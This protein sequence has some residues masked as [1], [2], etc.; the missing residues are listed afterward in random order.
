MSEKIRYLDV[1]KEKNFILIWLAQ[2]AGLVGFYVTYSILILVVFT[3]SKSNFSVALMNATLLFPAIFLATYGGTFSDQNNKRKILFVTTLARAVL[4]LTLLFL[5]NDSAALVALFFV[6]F[7]FAVLSQFFVPAEAAA[8][9]VLIPSSKL[10][11]ANT[12]F[13]LTLFA[14]ILIGYS[15]GSLLFDVTGSK[16]PLILS[17]GLFFLATFLTYLLPDMP[18]QEVNKIKRTNVFKGVLVEFLG[19]ISFMW[20]RPL[21][22]R[23][24]IQLMTSQIVLGVMLALAPA[25]ILEVVGLE[26]KKAWLLIL[27]AGVGML[28]G[29]V[30]VGWFAQAR[31]KHRISKSALLMVGILLAALSAVREISSL[32]TI[33]YPGSEAHGTFIFFVILILFFIGFAVSG[34]F[35][36]AQTSLQLDAQQNERGKV[37][38]I[39][40]MTINIMTVFPLLI[41]GKFADVFDVSLVIMATAVLVSIIALVQFLSSGENKLN[42]PVVQ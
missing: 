9:P 35:V 15:S 2:I 31:D 25:F 37:F 23:S 22:R 24:I 12:L 4:V 33:R 39:L 17:A 19:S 18:P 7:L 21:I 36:P 1:L 8:I 40:N 41:A 30:L 20:R 27:P 16:G 10:L 42:K 26:I 34:V 28:L 13:S 11:K 14:S 38:G 5:I 3:L 32:L 29:A 6:T